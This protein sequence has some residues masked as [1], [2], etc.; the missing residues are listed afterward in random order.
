MWMAENGVNV[1]CAHAADFLE[2]GFALQ[3]RMEET[4]IAPTEKQGLEFV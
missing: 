4:G 3:F 2:H 1:F